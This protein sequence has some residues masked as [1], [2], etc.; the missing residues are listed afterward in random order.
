MTTDLLSAIPLF[1]EMSAGERADLER[2]LQPRAY[3]PHHA[4]FWIGEPGDEFYIVKSGHVVIC[5]PDE[6]GTEVTLAVLGPGQFFGELSLLDGGRRTATARAQTAAHL[7]SLGRETF[8]Q[9]ILKHPAGAIHILTTLGRRQRENLDKLRGI[10]NA[11]E[12]VE[13]NRTP[14][15]RLTERVAGLFASEAFLV[16][17]LLFF[18]VWVVWHTIRHQGPINFHDDPPTFF[19]L[20][21]L[22]TIEAIILSMFVLNSQRRQARRDAIKIDLDYQVNRK[23]Q[24]GITE[25]HEKLDRLEMMLRDGAAAVS[26][27]P[28]ADGMNAPAP[29]IPPQN[30]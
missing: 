19:W 6:K 2:L 1:A 8:H 9:F 15:Q 21:F 4:I 7:L 23:A 27:A 10:K 3:E 11:N 13:E 29:A 20:G 18:V 22:V 24:L 17:N 5:Y 14:L 28:A 30:A 26:P 12:V 25:L 16:L